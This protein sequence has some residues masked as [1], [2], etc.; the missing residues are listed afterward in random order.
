M[1]NYLGTVLFNAERFPVVANF[2]KKGKTYY[3]RGYYKQDGEKVDFLFKSRMRDLFGGSYFYSKKL[4]GTSNNLKR[5]LSK[6][7]KSF[8]L[9]GD[10]RE[11][12]DSGPWVFEL[13]K[14]DKKSI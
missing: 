8:I 1:A 9:N 4:G 13:N 6:D 10:W 2:F 11:G 7:K 14:I 5:F 3:L 12:V